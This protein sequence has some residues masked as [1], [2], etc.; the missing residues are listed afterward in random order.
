MAIIPRH[1]VG[2]LEAILDGRQ[3]GGE[4]RGD[5][6]L[7]RHQARLF[8]G[9]GCQLEDPAPLV[10][11]PQDLLA[12]ASGI[13]LLP[14]RKKNSKRSLPAYVAYV[15]HY[16]RKRVET[17]ISLLERLLPKTIHAVTADGFELKVFLFVLACSFEGLY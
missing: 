8:A 6:G 3:P 17:S 16:I 10:G 15:Q 14:L 1:G 11:H 12:E 9:I 13:T 4:L 7:Q 5:L 2:S